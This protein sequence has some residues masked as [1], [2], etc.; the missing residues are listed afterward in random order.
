MNC[1][2][3]TL[4]GKYPTQHS[5]TV[6][7]SRTLS[8]DGSRHWVVTANTDSKKDSE[9]KEPPHLVDTF[10]ETRGAVDWK[11]DDHDDSDDGNDQ[12]LAV[13]ELATKDI[14]HETE[15]DLPNN[16]A[17]VGGGVDG[18]PNEERN[19]WRGDFG[20]GGQVAS[21]EEL[22]SPERRSKVDN[23]EIVAVEH[24]TYATDGIELEVG[25]GEDLARIA[26]LVIL[27]GDDVAM[28]VPASVRVLFPD[29]HDGGWR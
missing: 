29:G 7:D 17:D 28:L 25:P 4:V 2:Y 6:G 15:T 14:A 3:P 27:E 13:D 24:E 22:I 18:T 12:F 10:L 26:G 1:A 20:R 11:R 16:V 8:D 19:G 21:V 23:E 9:T 5:A